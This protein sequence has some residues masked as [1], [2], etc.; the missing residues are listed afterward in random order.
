MIRNYITEDLNSWTGRVD[1]VDDYD[2]FRWHQWIQILDLND[3]SVQPF[4][5][6]VGIGIIGFMCDYG[7][8]LNKGRVGAANGPKSIRRQLA[9]LPCQFD[10]KLKLFDCGNVFIDDLSLRE[11]Q[12]SLAEAVDKILSLNLF[13]IVLG[14]G[15]ETAFGHYLGLFKHFNECAEQ[16]QKIGIINF[17]A[18][19]DTRPYKETGAS[20]G[21]M[22]RQIHDLN[23]ENNL[24]FAYMVMGIQKHSNTNSLFKYAD[25]VGIQYV[26]AKE[27]VHGDLYTQI[28]KLDEFLKAQDKIYVTICADVFSTSYAPGVSA[29]QPL[30][31]D[32]EKLLVF[33]KH[34]FSFKKVVSFDI[35]EVSPRFDQ[36]STTASLAAALIYTVV[37]ALDKYR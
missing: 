12:D 30:G 27:I 5:G 33:L 14:G 29:P 36:D 13:P 2:S 24:P 4:A 16:K 35:A 23:K 7:I 3:E 31:L 21:T 32:P 19:F 26:L 10:K 20:S 11:A 25:E 34:I 17:D 28:E 8:N 9:N 15:H 37:M 18:H 22:F 6:T 1:S